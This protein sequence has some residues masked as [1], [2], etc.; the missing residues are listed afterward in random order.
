MTITSDG[1]QGAD[2]LVIDRHNPPNDDPRATAI[3][4]P[5]IAIHEGAGYRL[6]LWLKAEHLSQIRVRFGQATSPYNHCGLDRLID[7]S[8]SWRK[9]GV[10]FR[11]E[12][13]GCGRD[14]N[15]LSIDVGQ[16]TGRLWFSQ[17]FLSR[18]SLQG[19]SAEQRHG[20]GYSLDQIPPGE[21][22]GFFQ[23][24]VKPLQPGSLHP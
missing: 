22:P 18:E 8:S 10:W 7:T 1:P 4:F 23:Q 24:A 20:E 13:E 15:R 12:G 17:I 3:Y 2:S 6:S 9:V 21:P 19:S 14:Q 5:G 11:A 16:S